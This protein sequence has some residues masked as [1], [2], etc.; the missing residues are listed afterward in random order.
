MINLVGTLPDLAA[1]LAIPGA[2]VHV[3]GKSERAGRKI[4]HVT[5]RAASEGE[6]DQQ[7]NAVL[8]LDRWTA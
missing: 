6:R 8:A 2:H 7:L 4:G 1:V 3:Y 5:V